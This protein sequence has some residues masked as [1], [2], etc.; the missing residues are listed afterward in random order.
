MALDADI[1]EVPCDIIMGWMKSPTSH[2]YSQSFPSSLKIKEER[3]NDMVF[4]SARTTKPWRVG[5]VEAFNS[6][7]RTFLRWPSELYAFLLFFI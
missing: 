1:F 6:K 5:S 3:K 2:E 4:A 7:I